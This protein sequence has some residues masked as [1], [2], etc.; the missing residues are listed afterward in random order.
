M[1]GEATVNS[2]GVTEYEDA[3]SVSI[4]KRFYRAHWP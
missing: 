4:P 2:D 3:H 1:I